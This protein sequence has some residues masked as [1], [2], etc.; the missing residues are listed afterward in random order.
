MRG[1]IL[2]GLRICLLVF[3]GATALCATP[4]MAGKTVV[5]WC[6][7]RTEPF[8]TGKGQGLAHDFVKMLNERA[9]GRFLFTLAFL[10]RKRIDQR[11]EYH[12]PG[13]VL[14]VNP[15]WMNDPDEERYLWTS[16]MLRDRNEII[17][18][19]SRPV[20]YAGVPSLFGLKL[21]GVFG[22]RYAPLEQAVATG[23]ILREDSASA[24]LN[25]LKVAE[26]RVDFI[27]MPRSQAMPLVKSLKIGHRLHFSSKP[28]FLYT[29]HVLVT[30]EL[31][32]VYAFLED[33]MRKI[34]DDPEWKRIREKYEVE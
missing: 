13:V 8:V 25:L 5:A 12:E 14:F 19:A 16:P 20:E 31:H 6:Y 2:F 29:R 23:E 30:R 3:W 28:L 9:E 33:F 24:R 22:R 21:G 15:I 27:T 18:S 7:Y 10:P 11:L 1:N 17:S 4:V 26:R 32:D 34:P